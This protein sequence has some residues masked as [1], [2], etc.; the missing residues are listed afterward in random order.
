MSKLTL[1]L[2]LTLLVFW[3]VG[4]TWWFNKKYDQIDAFEEE[5][6]VIPFTVQDGNFQT[7]SENTI[8]FELS[9]WEPTI[10]MQT[11]ASLKSVALYLANNNKKTLTLTGW[12]GINETNNSDFP[13]N[14]L[15][16][17]DAIKNELLAYGAPEAN[18]K[19]ASSSTDQIELKCG[20]ILG[21]VDFTWDTQPTLAS[22]SESLVDSE[23]TKEK[24]NLSDEQAVNNIPSSEVIFD[25]K[26][27]YIVF[28][29][30][31]TYRPKMDE[32][33]DTYFKAL[34][35]YLKDHPRDRLLLMGHTDNVG[36]KKKHFNFGKY[37]ARKL[38]DVLLEYDIEKRR[39]K[40]DS[41]GSSKPLDS[42]STKE[43]RF[44]NR[45]VEITIIKR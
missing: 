16:R 41:K 45:R 32:E 42:N 12:F 36:D 13:N 18:I 8:I 9:D 40:T 6:C 2:L 23:K 22:A 39:I 33:K 10:P 25:E 17:A 1:P 21:G 14:G 38:R 15:A 37:R 29:E 28:Y 35:K 11:L 27:T 20:K 7:K 43:G 34:A 30:E 5:A 44:K 24:R 19:I 26:K 31:N 4:A 3:L